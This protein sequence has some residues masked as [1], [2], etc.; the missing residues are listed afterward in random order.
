VFAAQSAVRY[1]DLRTL[2]ESK[3]TGRDQDAVD[4]AQLEELLCRQQPK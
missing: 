3:R 4:V 2:I 1:L